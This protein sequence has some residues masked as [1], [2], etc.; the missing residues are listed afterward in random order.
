MSEHQFR[1]LTGL[2]FIVGSIL[3]NIPYTLLIMNFNYPDIL[4]K[5]ADAVLMQ[6][7]AGGAS[8]IFTWLAFAWVGLPL[9]F[10][11]LML[12]RVLEPEGHPL[13]ETAT[14]L[15]L[16]G[17]VLAVVGLTRWVFVVPVLARLY[18]DP[19]SSEA[20]RS[21]ALVTFQ[22]IHQYGGVVIGEHISQLMTVLW[23]ALISAMMLRSVLFQAWQ[24]WLG[25]VAALVYLLAQS[26]LLATVIPGFPV[27][28]EA[29]LIGSLLW[30]LWMIV[31]GVTLLRFRPAPAVQPILQ[32]ATVG[33][34]AN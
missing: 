6:F 4:R 30:L 27:A 12:K 2:L 23:M 3:V 18:T 19:A 15:G 14:T 21:S 1:K 17:L 16:I 10:A 24:A 28:P 31:M 25:L 33:R 32:V 5:P 34:Q 20:I 11:T 7:Q 9:I 29:G 22:A 26:E 8:L 13:L